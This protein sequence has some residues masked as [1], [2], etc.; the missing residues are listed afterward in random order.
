MGYQSGLTSTQ[1]ISVE[2]GQ[3]NY[4]TPGIGQVNKFFG[5]LGKAGTSIAAGTGRL[6]YTVTGGKKFYCSSIHF[7]SNAGTGWELRDGT[8]I[9]GSIVTAGG[10]SAPTYQD[11]IF[12]TPIEFTTGIFI[13]VAATTLMTWTITGWEQ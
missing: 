6:L 1:N 4:P 11:L 3:T 7:S 9:A 8:T 13:D 5:G 2:G 12:P 10:Y